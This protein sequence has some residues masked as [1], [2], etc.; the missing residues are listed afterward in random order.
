MLD[1]RIARV[2]SGQPREL[3]EL[4]AI[5]PQHVLERV[6]PA[7]HLVVRGRWRSTCRPRRCQRQAGNGRCE[8]FASRLRRADHLARTVLAG[9]AGLTVFAHRRI[10]SSLSIRSMRSKP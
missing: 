9:V 3:A 1:L 4:T 6:L 10:S 5:A 2:L 7:G 8:K